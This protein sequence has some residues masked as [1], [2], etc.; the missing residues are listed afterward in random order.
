M[1]RLDEKETL[2]RRPPRGVDR[3]VHKPVRRLFGEGLPTP[4]FQAEKRERKERRRSH[5]Q[6]SL[7]E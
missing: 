4:P 2:W 6:F 7:E 1:P 3:L 5:P